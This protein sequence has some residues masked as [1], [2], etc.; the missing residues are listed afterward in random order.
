M[1]SK[2]LELVMKA[3]IYNTKTQEPTNFEKNR[4]MPDG[5]PPG[6]RVPTVHSGAFPVA[7]DGIGQKRSQGLTGHGVES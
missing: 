7:L 2:L 3:S 4:N 6:L 1:S 5:L